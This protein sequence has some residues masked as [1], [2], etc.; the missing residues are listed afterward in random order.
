MSPATPHPTPART[1]TWPPAARVLV[2]VLLV[3]YFAAVILPP[4]AGPP[5][6]SEL[7]NAV[8][9]PFRPLIGLL[10]LG[11]GYRFFA[12]DPG[13]GHSIRWSMQMP[14]GS[15]RVGWIPDA[16]NDR[17]RLLY[18]RRFM[19]SE[20]IATFV[21]FVDAPEAVRIEAKPR[22]QPLVKGVAG[23]LLA[24]HRGQQVALQLVEHY[25]PTP[26]EVIQSHN[27]EDI[28]TPL[29][30]YAFPEGLLP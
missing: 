17:P 12:P 13:P 19:I 21:P 29:G 9:Q 4:L 24:R 11:H 27:G 18:H 2:T 15:T 16:A 7:A 23:Q 14:D 28:I 10:S 20:K 30:T 1:P 5:P 22:W 26:E 25:L 8:I 6:A 3:A